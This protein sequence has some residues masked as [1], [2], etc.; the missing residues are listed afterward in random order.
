MDCMQY[1]SHI[2]Q[3]IDTRYDCIILI[4]GF[5]TIV[6]YIKFTTHEHS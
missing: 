6:R 4:R 2:E 3:N 1:Y 5:C